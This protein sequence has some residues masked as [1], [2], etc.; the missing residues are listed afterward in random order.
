MNRQTGERG[1]AL[2]L[3]IGITAALAILAAAL[4]LM[5][6]NQQGATASARTAKTS[7]FYAEAALNSGINAI[8]ATTVAGT[9]F[10]T[11]TDIDMTQ[12]NTQYVTA[13]PSP[14]PVPTCTVYDNATPV[15]FSVHKDLNADHR[16]WVE[17]SVTFR[18]RTSRLRAML[19]SDTTSSILPK[20]ALYADTDIVANGTGDIY[21]VQP[22]TGAPYTTSPRKYITSVMAGSDF[23]GNTSTRLAA[24]GQTAQSLGVQV[25]GTASLPGIPSPTGV[26]FG[27]V[28]L[29][30]D[31]FDQAH[32]SVLSDLSQLGLT[33]PHPDVTI[34]TAPTIPGTT[35]T[36][37]Q[38][39]AI[40][41]TTPKTY[42]APTDFYYNGNLTLG[43]TG[44]STFNFR[45][46]YLTGTLTVT[47]NVTVNATDLRVG[48]LAVSGGSSAR[49]FS[50]GKL[51]VTGTASVSGPVALSTTSVYT[52]ADFTHSPTGAVTDTLGPLY[53]VGNASVTGTVA[54]TTSGVHTGGN[55]TVAGPAS[56]S[57]SVAD[58]LGSVHVNGTVALTGNVAVTA[59][60]V[61]AGGAFTISG[62]TTSITESFGDIRALADIN[63]KG[64]SSG[65]LTVWAGNVYARR[66]LV[67]GDTSGN[68]VSGSG[69][70]VLHLGYTWIDGDAGTGNVAINLSAPAGTRC[71]VMCPLMA[72]TEKT[73][74][75]GLVDCG[76][77]SEPMVYYMQC[78]N[79]GLYTNTCA[80]ASTGQFTGLMIVMEAAITIT[81]GNDNTH[82]NIV[83]SV[84]CNGPAP[85][86]PTDITLSG[87]SS[88]CYD[89]RVIENLPVALRDILRT[90]TTTTV[91]G[92][93]QQLSAN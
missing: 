17:A 28:G 36:S 90:T 51:Y 50:L 24:P 16:L 39:T 42:N 70:Y 81:G 53:V 18:G 7:L 47:G 11:T 88:V 10:S 84:M 27:G 87:N 44:T 38:R 34:P 55:F 69:A 35:M 60:D 21:A 62:T 31:Y 59:T 78:D 41:T 79:D 92:T 32:Q 23:V 72:T 14:A 71:T 45:R 33:A 82:P 15:D 76:S 9:N 68:Y 66:L 67:D 58:T 61:Y 57:T 80:W 52:G 19:T 83:G 74:S 54:L 40:Q 85:A 75:N 3:L 91:P 22:V 20:A 63:W 65:V 8:K 46:L 77:L 37:A 49:T 48:S 5:L 73:V 89:H 30:S 93:W 56:G 25:N 86:C 4:V 43:S 1:A 13:Y 6:T 26:L 2:I 64:G 29:L 12:M